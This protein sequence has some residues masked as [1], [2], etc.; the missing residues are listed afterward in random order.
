MDQPQLNPARRPQVLFIQTFGCQMNDYDSSC[1]QRMLSQRGYHLTSDPALADVIFLN[2]CAVREKAEQKVYSFLGRL[3]RLKTRHPG[4]KILVA[5]CMAQQLGKKLLERFD[6][7]DLVV[8][9]R[10]LA[11]LPRLLEDI[12]ETDARLSHLAAEQDSPGWI[13]V[14]SAA[15]VSDVAAPVTIMQGCD[16]FCTYC[17]VPY[18]RGRER[19]R[20]SREI[21]DEIRKLTAAGAREV[22]LLGQNVNSY[23]KNS[24]E[25]IDF[26]G[27][28]YKIQRETSVARLRF[29]TSHPKDLTDA[30]IRCFAELDCLCTHLHLPVQSGSDRILQRMNRGYSAAG[31]LDKIARL[32]RT[33]PDM[34]LSSDVIVGFPGET[35]QDFQATLQLLEQVRF[36]MLFSFRYSDRPTTKAAQFDSKVPDTVKARRLVTLQALQAE[37]TLQRN[38]AEIG[39]VRDLLVEGP[40][41]TGHGQWTGR[42]QQN[43]TTNFQSP[44]ELTGQL[45][46]I[47]ITAAYSHSLRGEVI[48]QPL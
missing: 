21:I 39:R 22:T 25:G 37:I 17:I 4:L 9:T 26:V 46:Q 32:R 34:G 27:L 31:Y 6:H 41:K 11:E 8:G 43:R 1:V 14:E 13:G 3:R 12:Q 20:P 28:L 5:G 47:E 33:C 44:A 23:G 45:V 10:G 19:S 30:L 15:M 2:T 7:V 16:N 40:S 38:Q 35:D 36:D 18:V 29:T 42:T 24:R 48:N